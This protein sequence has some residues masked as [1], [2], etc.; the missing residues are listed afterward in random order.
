MIFM[1]QCETDYKQVFGPVGGKM[2]RNDMR[3]DASPIKALKTTLKF[4]P[5]DTGG[6]PPAEKKGIVVTN[7]KWLAQDAKACG[8]SFAKIKEILGAAATLDAKANPS[9][10]DIET[11][12]KVVRKYWKIVKRDA[13][14]E[15]MNGYFVN[16]W[17]INSGNL[18]KNLVDE[19]Q[20]ARYYDDCL[21][22]E[23][24][25]NKVGAVMQKFVKLRDR[26]YGD[27][28]RK[29]TPIDSEMKEFLFGSEMA[30]MFKAF[31]ERIA[32]N[33]SHAGDCEAGWEQV[34]S[35]NRA[36]AEEFISLIGDA[37]DCAIRGF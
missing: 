18:N 34:V 22:A 21:V 10:E 19:E 29:G 36:V 8:L 2:P 28:I 20:R 12:M 26:I 6:L 13:T 35:A 1:A 37:L 3:V 23:E 9:Q 27:S 31:I 16:L 5:F 7:L 14:I 4:S 32:P 25:P 17:V 33:T 15:M 30:G 11:A 24:L